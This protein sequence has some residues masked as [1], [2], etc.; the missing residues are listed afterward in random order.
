MEQLKCECSCKH[1]SFELSCY[2]IEIA[3]CYCSICANI[4]KSDFMA[5]VKFDKNCEK[6]LE[7]INLNKIHIHKSSNRAIRGLCNKCKDSIFMQYIGS[8]NI[9]IN[10]NTFKFPHDNIETYDIYKY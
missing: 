5:F 8:N 3:R 10:V 1:I 7:S 6:L 4:S 9:W 2:P